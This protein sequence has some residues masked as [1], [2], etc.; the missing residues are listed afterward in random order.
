MTIYLLYALIIFHI[1]I[2]IF[3]ILGGLISKTFA[4]FN[5]Y[6][7]LPFIYI[8]QSLPVHMIIWI[9]IYIINLKGINHTCDMS[10][11]KNT[12]TYSIV[13]K[14][15]NSLNVSTKTIKNHF[16]TLY[17]YDKDFVIGDIFY[18]IR[19]IFENSFYNPLSPQG[20][21]ILGYI[22]NTYSLK[23]LYV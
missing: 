11:N 13:K 19:D 22:I 16:D 4:L 12:P 15:A 21:I 3:S 6:I 7:L 10:H 23:Y 1:F 5:I 18:Q 2:W 20:L 17:C 14:I 9:K 8:F